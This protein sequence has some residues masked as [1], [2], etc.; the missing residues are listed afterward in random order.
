MRRSRVYRD[1][2]SASVSKKVSRPASPAPRLFHYSDRLGEW[3]G[4]VLADRG[5]AEGLGERGGPRTCDIVA[6]EVEGGERGREERGE[7]EA[8]VVLEEAVGERDVGWV[9]ESRREGH[10]NL[11]IIDCKQGRDSAS[12]QPG[13]G[14]GGGGLLT[15]RSSAGR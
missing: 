14:G 15:R 7:G 12:E 8:A 6:L 3:G 1:W 9:G 11:K 10:L 2:H 4:S 5:V 13:G